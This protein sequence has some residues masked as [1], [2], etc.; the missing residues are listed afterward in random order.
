MNFHGKAQS[1]IGIPSPG[2]KSEFELILKL[3]LNEFTL[4]EKL[5]FLPI[6]VSNKIVHRDYFM[7]R[8]TGMFPNR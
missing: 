4:V 7:S 6:Y 1:S 8:E 5:S 2:L 3:R